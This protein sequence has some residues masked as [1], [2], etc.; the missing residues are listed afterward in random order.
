MPRLYI[1]LAAFFALALS[2]RAS[3]QT[4]I[5]RLRGILALADKGDN[6]LALQRMREFLQSAP[7]SAEALDLAGVLAT[8]QG[9]L[10]EAHDYLLRAARIRP[11][12]PRILSN[13]GYL[14]IQRNDPSGAVRFL[15]G[16]L[17]LDPDSSEAAANLRRAVVLFN[18]KENTPLCTAMIERVKTQKLNDRMITFSE[19]SHP[20][21]LEEPQWLIAD[22]PAILI[23]R[24]RSKLTLQFEAA[25]A[26]AWIFWS[27]DGNSQGSESV[28]S[29]L[30][31]AIP[32]SGNGPLLLTAS[33]QVLIKGWKVE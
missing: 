15:R 13:L 21:D 1:C 17:L 30:A 14:L 7:Q 22:F 25:A 11:D 4:D 28:G 20:C 2:A 3:E 24:N 33:R 32:L 5:A 26:D 16:A 10:S 27:L 12:S 8:R 18:R 19:S 23:F 31:T 29:A 6:G 9:L